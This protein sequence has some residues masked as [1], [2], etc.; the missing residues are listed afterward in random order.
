M[1]MLEH[2]NNYITIPDGTKVLVKHKG[3]M[4]LNNEIVLHD[5][6]HVPYFQ[7]NLISVNKLCKDMKGTIS[8]TDQACFIQ[9]LSQ[10]KPLKLGSLRRGLFY[11]DLNTIEKNGSQTCCVAESGS[12]ENTISH[13]VNSSNKKLD[14][15]KLWHL[16]LGH[17]SFHN[18]HKVVPNLDV[19]S[20]LD[21]YFCQICPMAK[22]A[23][24]PFPVSHSRST[25]VFQLLHLDLWGPYRTSTFEGCTMFLTIVDDY[26][27]MCWVFFLKNKSDVY[28]VFVDFL[29][30]ISNHF[31]IGVKNV[32]TDNALELCEGKL[33]RFYKDKGI[34]HQ[35][36]CAYT[37]QQ[38]GIVERKHKTRFRGSKSTIFSVQ[39]PIKI[40]GR[41]C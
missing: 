24:L 29:A 15:V 35:S 32:R 16:R 6:L 4:K 5:V 40:L 8:F 33:K 41:M 14:D 20:C 21:D 27:R 23:I 3:T 17:M 1:C 10:T 19:K 22:Q 36:S 11:L 18:L 38:N 9:G 28:E 2:L 26:S 13:S 12:T 25:D 30:Y 37:P 7:F 34:S 31:H 39:S